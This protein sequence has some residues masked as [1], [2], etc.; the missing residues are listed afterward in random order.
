MTGG[1]SIVCTQKTVIDQT[2]FC[3]S[4]IVCKI[5]VVIGA[6]QLFSFSRYQEM[7]TGR[8]TRWEFIFETYR[9][10]T[11]ISRTRIFENMV[12]NAYQEL[13]PKCKIESFYTTGKQ[14]KIDSFHVDGY[15]DDRKTVFEAMGCYY[16]F[17][18]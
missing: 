6:S 7:P 18:L 10:K 15:C 17:W 11:R 12:I 4:S 16:H 3:N 2:Y 13:R 8:H 5:I 9:F 14:N 1:P